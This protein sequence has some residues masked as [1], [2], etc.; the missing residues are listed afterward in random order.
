MKRRH[1][2]SPDDPNAQLV[3]GHLYKRIGKDA[4]TVAAY[5]RAVQN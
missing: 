1:N 2:S 4:E 5:Q 3:L